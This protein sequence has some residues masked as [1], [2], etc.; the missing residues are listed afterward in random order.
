VQHMF[1]FSFFYYK[2]KFSFLLLGI[3]L[4]AEN[5]AYNHFNAC[6]FVF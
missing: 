2:F 4:K 6:E 5:V 1:V 3:Q